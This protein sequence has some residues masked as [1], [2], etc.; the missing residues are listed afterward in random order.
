[1][2]GKTSHWRV[3]MAEVIPLHEDSAPLLTCAECECQMWW[4]VLDGFRLDWESI[5]KFI[6]SECGLCIDTKIVKE[7]Q[8]A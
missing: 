7:A 3:G 1:M 2:K 6:C 5:V 4:I 8:G